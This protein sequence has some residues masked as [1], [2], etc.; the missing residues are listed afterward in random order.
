MQRL[1]SWSAESKDLITSKMIYLADHRMVNFYIIVHHCRGL[2]SAFA[3]FR[4]KFTF[5]LNSNCLKIDPKE[6]NL[7]NAKLKQN[8]KISLHCNCL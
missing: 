2:H 6:K 5:Q 3:E 4:Q 1:C 7:P 8:L